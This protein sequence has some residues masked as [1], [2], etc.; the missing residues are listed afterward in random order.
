MQSEALLIGRIF[1]DRGNRMGPTH[2][3]KNGVKYRY[4]LSSALTD[5]RPEDAS[6]VSRVPATEIEAQILRSVREHL[7]LRHDLNDKDV[8]ADHVSRIEVHPRRLSLNSAT[9]SD[10]ETARDELRVAWQKPPSKRRREL[11][12]P[13]S[14]G[15]IDHPADP[16][17]NPRDRDRSHLTRAPV[18]GRTHARSHSD[19]RDDRPSRRLQL[20]QSEHDNLARIHLSD[21]RQSRA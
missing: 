13:A 14:E 10:F 2:A 3:R 20:T 12:R 17:G 1:D 19:G 4:Y 21:A 8:I 18:A 6:A 16:R 15:P 5:G 9:R 7:Q 11:L